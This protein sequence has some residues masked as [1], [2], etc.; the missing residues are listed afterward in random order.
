L[1]QQTYSNTVSHD[2]IVVWPLTLFAWHPMGVHW[3]VRLA[4]TVDCQHIV[5]RVR[6]LINS[7]VS[8]FTSFSFLI[9]NLFYGVTPIQEIHSSLPSYSYMMATM[10]WLLTL[11]GHK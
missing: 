5:C 9:F 10:Y 3:F 6:S 8:L 11:I 1:C 4:E 7:Q 2:F